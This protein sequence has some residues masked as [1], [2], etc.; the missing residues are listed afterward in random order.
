MAQDLLFKG[1]N[2]YYRGL[3]RKKPKP[4]LSA[5]PRYDRRDRNRLRVPPSR[6]PAPLAPRRPSQL[7]PHFFGRDR[8]FGRGR[9]FDR[10]RPP[11]VQPYIPTPPR[12]HTPDIWS[13]PSSGQGPDDYA[14]DRAVRGEL[15]LAHPYHAGPYPTEPL[16]RYRLDQMLPTRGPVPF[17]MSD[18]S[19]RGGIVDP[20]LGPVTTPPS[21]RDRDILP[22]QGDQDRSVLR[23]ATGMDWPGA[24]NVYR[25]IPGIL[26]SRRQQGEPNLTYEDVVREMEHI[27]RTR[28]QVPLEELRVHT[29]RLSRL[30]RASRRPDVSHLITPPLSSD[31]AEWHAS[32]GYSEPMTV[33]GRKGRFNFNVAP[34]PSSGGPGSTPGLRYL[35]ETDDGNEYFFQLERQYQGGRW[36][37]ADHAESDYRR[38][39]SMLSSADVAAVDAPPSRR[40]PRGTKVFDGPKSQYRDWVEIYAE[41]EGV[42]PNFVWALSQPRRTTTC[43]CRALIPASISP[44]RK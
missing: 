27:S 40:P 41:R 15:G 35:F 44:T 6:Q 2:F 13:P 25:A 31:M 26:E 23:S 30:G 9:P 28:G 4:P 36:E 21:L 29:D 5:L 17:D 22:W 7:D 38:Y 33:A 39:Q 43:I 3:R 16:R 42:D 18:P 37:D 32:G 10:E 11:E 14:A 8:P 12:R 24:N 34:Q 1:G 20:I 19:A